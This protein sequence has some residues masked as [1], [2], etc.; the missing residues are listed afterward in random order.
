MF[1][2]STSGS[3]ASVPLHAPQGKSDPND[4]L[5]VETNFIPNLGVKIIWVIPGC[6]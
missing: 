2:S 6:S 5:K 1:V 3:G 4:V